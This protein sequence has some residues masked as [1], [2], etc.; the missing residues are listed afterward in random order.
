[1]RRPLLL[2][3]SLALLG[4][5]GDDESTSS[6]VPAPVEQPSEPENI[7]EQEEVPP[8]LDIEL[9]P[10]EET[11]DA[12]PPEVEISLPEPVPEDEAPDP[13]PQPSTAKRS[14]PPP[15]KV[16]LPEPELD[17]RLPEELVEELAPGPGDESMR[18]LPPLFEGGGPSRSMQIG[19][20]LISGEAEDEE[21]IE[22]AEIRL[23]FKR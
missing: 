11:S 10:I 23:E 14:T 9:A 22:G 20:R 19:G 1:M 4:G 3:L 13:A 12:E 17:L 7:V 21:L 18:L 2:L 15:A 6:R 5:C 16:E 8:D